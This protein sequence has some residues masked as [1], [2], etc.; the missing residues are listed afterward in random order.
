MHA[1]RTRAGIVRGTDFSNNARAA[2]EAAAA[3]VAAPR[4]PMLLV[5]VAP[6]TTKLRLPAAGPGL[7]HSRGVNEPRR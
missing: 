3:L 5:R 4:E 6:E 1:T 2:G 7:A